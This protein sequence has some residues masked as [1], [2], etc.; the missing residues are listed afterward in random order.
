MITEQEIR[1]QLAELLEL[2]KVEARSGSVSG[3]G[4]A[5]SR[6]NAILRDGLRML[7]WSEEAVTN[8]HVELGFENGVLTC[9]IKI[10]DLS[11]LSVGPV[12][13]SWKRGEP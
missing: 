2:I 6:L 13:I 7:G 12:N 8:A 4:S 10:L 11:M 1:A 9:S 3:T 5:L